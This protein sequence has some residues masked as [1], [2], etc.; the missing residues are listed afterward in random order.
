MWHIGDAQCTI[1][2]ICA[3]LGV[4]YIFNSGCGS[5]NY[6]RR[7]RWIGFQ[8]AIS[9]CGC[10]AGNCIGCRAEWTWIDGSSKDY[11]NW[12]RGE[13]TSGEYYAML[14]AAGD[15]HGFASEE[16]LKFICKTREPYIYH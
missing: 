11:T 16:K 7:H 8:N 1:T 5:Q 15:W 10:N 2:L 4:L 9:T 6:S 12:H 13:P 14:T 3:Q